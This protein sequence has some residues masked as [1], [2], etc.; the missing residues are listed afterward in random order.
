MT[1]ALGLNLFTNEIPKV[2]FSI[3]YFISLVVIT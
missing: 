3:N 2:Y 1:A